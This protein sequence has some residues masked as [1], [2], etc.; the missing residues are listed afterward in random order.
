MA[1]PFN[2]NNDYMNMYEDADAS[3][4]DDVI[5]QNEALANIINPTTQETQKSAE[6]DKPKGPAPEIISALAKQIL[7][8]SD[9]SKWTGKGFGSVEKNAEDMARILANAGL[10]DV[11][12]LGVKQEVVPAMYYE[13]GETPE[14]TVNKYYNKETGQDLGNL[15]GT[16][17]ERQTGNFFG[18]TFEGKG[19]T[20]YGVQFR[21]DGTPVFYTQGASSNDVAKIMEMAGPVGQIAAATL[22][23]PVAVAAIAAASGKPIEDIIKSAALSYLGN[24]AGSAVSGMEGITDA[25]GQTGTKIVSN[26]AKQFVGSGGN[27]DP[28]QALLSGG[29]DAGVNSIAE[30][31]GM[32]DLT[33]TQQKLVST[34]VSG[35]VAGKTPEQIAMDLAIAGINTKNEIPAAKTTDTTNSTVG[36]FEDK[37]VTRLKGLGYTNAQIRDYFGRLDNL[38]EAFE[39]PTKTLSV[40]DTFMDSSTS[41]NKDSGLSNQDILNMVNADTLVA[42]TGNDSIA[43]GAGNDSLTAVAGNDIVQDLANSGLTESSTADQVASITGAAGNDTVVSGQE[44]SGGAGKDDTV[45]IAS[46]KV[47]PEY[48]SAGFPSEAAYLNFGKSK[49]AYDMFGGDS[50][51]YAAAKNAG[52]RALEMAVGSAEKDMRYDVNNDGKINSRDGLLISKG[53]PLRDDID[54]SGAA[55]TKTNDTVGTEETD[56]VTAGAGN[57]VVQQLTDSGLTTTEDQAA[58]IAGGDTTDTLTGAAGNDT[59]TTDTGIGT[60]TDTGTGTE[61]G[62]VNIVGSAGNDTITDDEINNLLDGLTLGGT[63][64][65]TG[66][67]TNNDILR[68]IGAESLIGGTTN[69]SITGGTTNDEMIITGTNTGTGTTTDTGTTQGSGTG[70]DITDLIGAF[71]NDGGDTVTVT[72][73]KVSDSATGTTQGA[74]TGLDIIDLIG[75][76]GN[77]GGETVTVTGNKGTG[78]ETATGTETGTGTVDTTT[79][80]GTTPEIITT[81]NKG[82]DTCPIGTVYNPITGMCDPAWDE[83]GIDTGTETTGT[84]PEIITT[85]NKSTETTGTGTTTGTEATTGTG[86]IPEIITTG[87]R[88]AGTGTTTGT[89]TTTGTGTIPEVI[90]TGNATTCPIGT[91]LNPITGNCDPYWDETDT[92]TVVGGTGNDSIVGGVTPTTPTTPKV[93]TPVKTPAATT[94]ATA[95]AMNLPALFALLSA[96]Q[97]PAQ[98]TPMQDPYAHIKLMED[99]FGSTIDLTPAGE[100]TAQRK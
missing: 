30:G 81:G 15:G 86:T 67:L 21:P 32:G 40:D 80:T 65:V 96:G 34:G 60:T 38:T 14:H 26:A 8:S 57:D 99:L 7:G 16:Y 27:I 56:T 3:F 97:Q 1:L 78:T 49:A 25:L 85:G 43:S 24:A 33:P 22:G 39:E 69:D 66:N 93:T 44:T 59:A 23:G 84:I 10:T 2:K 68:L 87:N 35:L 63:D 19:N 13:S 75:A 6:P 73:N 88:E 41:S 18:G 4:G 76:L 9:T 29:I 12:Q 89:E 52:K 70:L 36:N 50:E 17:A 98:Q 58:T 47:K 72:G 62:T 45:E 91:R 83:T 5:S 11:R 61:D 90:V 100:N 54:A 94:P 55:I 74:G 42:G 48:E 28:V 77:D 82:G 92:D 20:G 95:P 51:A 64:T 46:N 71:G 37:E 53:T 31:L 79:G